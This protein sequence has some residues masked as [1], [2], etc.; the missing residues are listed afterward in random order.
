MPV[1]RNSA[2][3]TAPSLDRRLS[4]AQG[5]RGNRKKLKHTNGDLP[6]KLS[7]FAVFTD[8]VEDVARFY[9]KLLGREPTHSAPGCALFSDGGTEVLVHETYEPGEDD[10]PCENHVAF[11]VDDLDAAFD[12]LRERGLEFEVPPRDL[13]WGRSAYLR[14]PAGNLIELNAPCCD[15]PPAEFRDLQGLTMNSRKLD[16]FIGA[17]NETLEALEDWDLPIRL[18]FERHEVEAV[19]DQLKEVAKKRSTI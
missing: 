5:L 9:E 1:W 15:T 16:L 3:W 19:L 13:P 12:E 18:G 11:E 6:V 7:E 2:L 10:L 8:A 17:L 14:D 4:I